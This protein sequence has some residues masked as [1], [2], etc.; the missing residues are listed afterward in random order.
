MWS[1][2]GP[3]GLRQGFAPTEANAWVTARTAAVTVLGR[4][5]AP[6]GGHTLAAAIEEAGT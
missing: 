6:L 4:M 1:V 5:E 3:G 2:D